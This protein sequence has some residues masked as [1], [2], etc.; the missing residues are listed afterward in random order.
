M[1]EEEVSE[2]LEQRLAKIAPYFDEDTQTELG[3]MF[4]TLTDRTDADKA[5]AEMQ[6]LGLL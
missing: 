2:K 6:D 3:R 1:P 4:E 5:L